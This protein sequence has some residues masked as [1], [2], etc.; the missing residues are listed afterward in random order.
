MKTTYS[1]IFAALISTPVIA[2]AKSPIEKVLKCSRQVI[3]YRQGGVESVRFVADLLTKVK[4]TKTAGEQKEL[5]EEC[6][7]FKKSERSELGISRKELIS[8]LKSLDEH[9]LG[10]GVTSTLWNLV[11]PTVHCSSKGFNIVAGLGISVEAGAEVGKCTSS[12][13]RRFFMVIPR[14]GAGFGIG[15]NAHIMLDS[16]R[17][18]NTHLGLFALDQTATATVGIIPSIN[19]RGEFEDIGLGLGLGAHMTGTLDF[20]LK[21]IPLI[22]DYSRLESQ[23]MNY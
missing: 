3:D 4:V 21:V 5:L 15:A 13:G 14:L 11:S 7:S 20:A 18:L 2:N 17:S 22:A 1:L 8:E 10:Y 16:S 9:V 6:E 23:L 19:F 12:N